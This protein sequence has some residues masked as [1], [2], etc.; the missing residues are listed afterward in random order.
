MQQRG[1]GGTRPCS[2]VFRQQIEC[3]CARSDRL[4]LEME[5]MNKKINLMQFGLVKGEME[6]LKKL[7]L[8]KFEPN[9][10]ILSVKLQYINSLVIHNHH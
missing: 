4:K 7:M 1:S 6:I 5:R 3:V 10:K 8:L 9:F 2:L